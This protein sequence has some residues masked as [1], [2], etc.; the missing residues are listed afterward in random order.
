M[1]RRGAIEI[2][3]VTAQPTI[4]LDSVAHAAYVRFSNNKVARTDPVCSQDCVVT[5]DFDCENKIVGIELVGVSDFGVEALMKR[6][7]LAGYSKKF[8]WKPRYV[9]AALQT[10]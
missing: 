8:A 2:A 9:P 1:K 3:G 6:A 10:A 7:G 5:L 4:E